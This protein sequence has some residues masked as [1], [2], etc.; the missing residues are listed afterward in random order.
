VPRA[1]STSLEFTRELLDKTGV[2]VGPGSGFGAAG[3]GYVRVALCVSEE[4][5]REA[6]RRMAA[7]GF[8]Y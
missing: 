4:R 6:A 7:A 3:E 2:V 5:L 1:Y 8:T